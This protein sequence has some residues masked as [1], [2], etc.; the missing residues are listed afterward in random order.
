MGRG[1]HKS[2]KLAVTVVYVGI[3]FQ[4]ES[5]AAR[6]KAFI[7]KQPRGYLVKE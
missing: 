1:C 6:L 7:H 3:R 4:E 2:V 5:G